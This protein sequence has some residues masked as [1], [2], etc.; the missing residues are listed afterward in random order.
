MTYHVTLVELEPQPVAMICSTESVEG[1]AGFLG[2]AF[3]EVM[4][5]VGSQGATPAGMPF[6]RYREADGRFDI[7]AGFP[8]AGPVTPDGDVEISELPG[9]PA[10]QTMHVGPYAEVGGAYHAVQA[11]LQS[12]GCTPTGAP[13]EQ[14]LDEP[15]VAQPR[16]LVT[17]PCTRPSPRP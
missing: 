10:A 6:A 17:F 13:W 3:G 7:Q 11:W 4:R 5:V 16:T 14:Y 15:T 1:I 8:V 12:N 9:G 2:R